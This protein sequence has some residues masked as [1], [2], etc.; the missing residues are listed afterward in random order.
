MPEMPFSVLVLIAFALAFDFLNG[1]HDS[2]NIVATMIASR[3]VNGRLALAITAIAEFIGPFLF[4]VAVATTIGSEVLNDAEIRLAVVMS[5]LLASII[6]NIITW[7]L[8]IPSSSSHALIGGL[9]GA[10]VVQNGWDVVKMSG[11]IKVLTALAISPPIGL[12]AGYLVMKLVLFL[13]RGASPSINVLFKS[14]QIVTA[15]A[16]A[17]SHGTN[18]AQKTMGIITLG[19][20]T[21]KVLPVF[22]VPLWVVAISASA[23]A[24]GTWVGGWRLI[25]TIGGKFFKIRPV[26]GFTTQ[27][28]SAGVILAAALLGGPVSTTQVVSSSLMGVGSAERVS[29]VRWTTAQQIVIAWITTIPASAIMAALLVIFIGRWI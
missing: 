2:S 10:A 4:G 24:L 15:L 25:K 29:K 14:G 18:D 6:W 27:V 26:H 1:F 16:L 11:L 5:A 8:G 19:L 20:V 17:L 9:I 21:A 12:A 7:W 28:A 13:A 23:I 3:A 22:E